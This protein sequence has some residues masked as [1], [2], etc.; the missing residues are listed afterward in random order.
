MGRTRP[1]P[2]PSLDRRPRRPDRRP[3]T[4]AG[5]AMSATIH[6][7]A[8]DDPESAGS[9]RL[10]ELLRLGSAFRSACLQGRLRL[11]LTTVSEARHVPV[12][13]DAHRALIEVQHA[14]Q[15]RDTGHPL[16]YG[17]IDGTFVPDRFLEVHSTA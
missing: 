11:G 5:R 3:K 4:G 16:E 7:P 10:S 6:R 1:D 13:E 17:V 15:N 9:R 14:F 2:N 8:N 12:L